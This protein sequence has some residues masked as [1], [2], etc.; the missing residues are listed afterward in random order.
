MGALQQRHL[1]TCRQRAL[2]RLADATL[3]LQAKGDNMVD[4]G[5]LEPLRQVWV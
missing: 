1:K 4:T 3:A 2:A 5:V